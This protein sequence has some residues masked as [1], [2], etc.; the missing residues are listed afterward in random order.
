MSK[1]GA[2][3]FAFRFSLSANLE[4][5]LVDVCMLRH[6]SIDSGTQKVTL[7]SLFLSMIN[8]ITITIQL[9]YTMTVSLS[10]TFDN[11][12]ILESILAVPSFREQS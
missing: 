3:Y 8:I 5:V 4:N 10:M 6:A 2:D 7:F 9:Q 12:I 11:D 1:R